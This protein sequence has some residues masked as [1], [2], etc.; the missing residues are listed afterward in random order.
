MKGTVCQLHYH[1]GGCLRSVH[2]DGPS[3]EAAWPFATA[4]QGL[5]VGDA[6]TFTLTG[7]QAVDLRGARGVVDRHTLPMGWA[8]NSRVV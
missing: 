6:V 3:C 5:K 7:G 1:S 8:D 2:P 4:P